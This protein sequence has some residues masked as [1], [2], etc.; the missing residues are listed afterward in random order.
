MLSH[1]R[2]QKRLC[3]GL[4]GGLLL[5]LIGTPVWAGV[6]RPNNKSKT[7]ILQLRPQRLPTVSIR[8]KKRVARGTEQPTKTLSAVLAQAKRQNIDLKILKKRMRLADL[9]RARSWSALLPTLGAVGSYVRNQNEANFNGI[10]ITPYNQF[11]LDMQVNWSFLNLQAISQVQIAGLR[12]VQQKWQLS[13]NRRELMVSV[14]RA[15]Y[16]VLLAQGA[17]ELSHDALVLARQQAKQAQVRMKA[18]Q[19]TALSVSQARLDVARSRQSQQ[20]AKNSMVQAQLSLALLLGQSTFPYRVVRPNRPA[21][22]Q[23]KA[24]DWLKESVRKRFVLRANRLAMAIAK[25]QQQQAWMA[26]APTASASAGLRVTNA[27]GFTG[28]AAQWNLGVNLRWDLFQG[29]KRLVGV[30]ESNTQFQKA[31]LDYH[32]AKQKVENEVRKSALS[33]RS[34]IESTRL[35]R[36]SVQLARQTHQHQRQRFASGVATPLA[37]SDAM[38]RLYSAEMSY[39]REQLNQELAIVE[40]QRSVG[41]F[42]IK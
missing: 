2:F 37:V 18:G 34:S 24:V 16:N 26:F 1:S 38:Y 30:Q 6:T 23:G 41:L 7:R 8:K 25:R 31:K 5:G 29:G 36:Q 11:S 15:Y 27:T 22:P 21:L 3:L 17:W 39:L 32:K 33:Y 35:A 28:E 42:S 10:L 14:V 12:R 19:A 13:Q 40:I 4:L 9:A 20:S